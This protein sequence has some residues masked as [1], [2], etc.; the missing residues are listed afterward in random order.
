[1]LSTDF[2]RGAAGGGGARG[3]QARQAEVLAAQDPNSEEITLLGAGGASAR[4]GAH[5]GSAAAWSAGC[6]AAL[7]RWRGGGRAGSHLSKSKSTM[8]PMHVQHAAP[9]GLQSGRAIHPPRCGADPGS[10]EV[11]QRVPRARDSWLGCALRLSLPLPP[12]APGYP[13]ALLQGADALGLC[14]PGRGSAGQQQQRRTGAG[15]LTPRGAG[16]RRP[17]ALCASLP[18]LDR[19][20]ASQG[21]AAPRCFQPGSPVSCVV[22][23]WSWVAVRCV[24]TLK[25]LTTSSGPASQVCCPAPLAARWATVLQ[26]SCALPCCQLLRSLPR[27]PCACRL[28]R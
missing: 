22:C 20:P 16:M 23:R 4:C 15:Q 19:H 13:L 28:Q 1:M 7:S 3:S 21:R 24:L 26:T 5:C 18:L 2:Q 14:G 10:A 11:R 17:A 8:A 25:T 9:H 12:Q 27:P 6:G